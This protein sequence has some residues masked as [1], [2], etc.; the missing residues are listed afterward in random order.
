MLRG[1]FRKGFRRAA[2][3]LDFGTPGM[4]R[5]APIG[6]TKGF[7]GDFQD[8]CHSPKVS[9]GGSVGGFEGGIRQGFGTTPKGF[10]DTRHAPKGSKRGGFQGGAFRGGL[11]KVPERV[12]ER[13]PRG[14]SR[15]TSEGL[16]EGFPRGFS[17]EVGKG[18]SGRLPRRAAMVVGFKNGRPRF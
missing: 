12:F 7:R 11:R 6:F 9:E 8:T 2:S 14:S 18:S 1:L 17:K 13:F 4:L 10:R 15:L 16:P 5:R 3:G